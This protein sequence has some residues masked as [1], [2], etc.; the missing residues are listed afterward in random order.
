MASFADIRFAGSYANIRCNKSQKGED[1]HGIHLYPDDLTESKSS[2]SSS[3]SGHILVHGLLGHVGKLCLK[4][5]SFSTPG[6]ILSFGV[7]S[8]LHR[9]E[10]EEFTHSRF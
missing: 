3:K 2:P 5:G 9:K 6:Q 10:A 1:I 4:S 7:P 8:V